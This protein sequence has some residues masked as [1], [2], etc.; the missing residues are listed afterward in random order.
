MEKKINIHFIGNNLCS[1]EECCSSC[2]WAPV[3]LSIPSPL[4][5]FPLPRLIRIKGKDIFLLLSIRDPF[6]SFGIPFSSC[7]CL[8]PGEGSLDQFGLR[9]WSNLSCFSRDHWNTKIWH[10]SLGLKEKWKALD[11]SSA[12]PASVLG[13]KSSHMTLSDLLRLHFG[14]GGQ[15][16]NYYSIHL[17]SL[18]L[19]QLAKL[20]KKV[21]VAGS[22]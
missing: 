12:W 6:F 7:L 18:T 11:L 2:P 9:H 15:W 22:Q 10:S 20:D 13:G 19:N 8:P 21:W 5:P 17:R 16:P 4:A 1:K 14:V 3:L